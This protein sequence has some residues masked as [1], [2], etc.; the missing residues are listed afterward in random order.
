VSSCRCCQCCC[1]LSN[2][3]CKAQPALLPLPAA[4]PLECSAAAS[5]SRSNRC[6][7]LMPL[8]LSLPMQC[9][10]TRELENIFEQIAKTLSPDI[11]VGKVRQVPC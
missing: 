8:W 2:S 10:V 6:P 1:H 3:A 7:L 9:P 11:S 4:S 5:L